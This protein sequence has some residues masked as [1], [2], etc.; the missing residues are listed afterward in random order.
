[1]DNLQNLDWDK[2]LS[3]LQSFATT[4]MARD[5]LAQTSPFS[6]PKS[7]QEQLDEIKEALQLV[8]INLRPNLEGL[9]SFQVWYDRLTKKATLKVS[10]LLDVKKF[11]FDVVSVH[12]ALMQIDGAWV[13]KSLKSLMESRKILSAI[14]QLISADGEIR[15]DASETLFNLFNE[16]KQLEKNIR[17]TLDRIVK[18][19][20]MESLLQDKYVTNREGRWVL[21]IKSGKQHDIEGIIHDSSQTKQTVFMEPQDIIPVN[22]RL[23]DVEIQIEKEVQKLLTQLSNF[24][25][26]QCSEFSQSQ[27][28]LL[29]FDLRMAQA[30]FTSKIKGHFFEFNDKHFKLNDVRHPLL[31][32]QSNMNVV[33][34]TVKFEENKKILIL[35]GPN[36][37]GKTILLKA[38]GLCAHM[39]RCGLPLPCGFGSTLPFFTKIYVAIGDT[40][41]VDQHLSTFA[42][43]LK[44]LTEAT[45]ARGSNQLILV[46]EICGST[47]PEEGAALSKAFIDHYASNK[48]YGIVTSHLGPLKQIWPDSSSI[49]CGSMEYDKNPTYKLFM[50]I[51][52]RSYAI[53]TA[54]SVG[55]PLSILDKA[56]EYLSPESRNKEI[57]MDEIESYKNQLLELTKKLTLENEIVEQQREKYKKLIVKFEAE[58]QIWIQKSIERAEKKIEKLIEEM[59]SEKSISLNKLK[60]ELPQII[61][62]TPS[63]DIIASEKDFIE[64]VVPGTS[65][66]IQSL[67]QDGI[68][69]GIPN[70]KGEVPV[71]SKSMRVQ[72]HWK[73]LTPKKVLSSVQTY[74]HKTSDAIPLQKEELQIDLRGLTSDDA[75][76][77]LERALDKAV[78]NQAD[79]IKI[80]HGHGSN[81]LKKSVRS[82]LSRSLYIQKWQAGSET[83]GDGITWAE[84]A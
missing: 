3:K 82:Y 23:R 25:S 16:K 83:E 7:A 33:P 42:A 11:C 62:Y 45:E 69:Q 15:S 12:K 74:A 39:A 52:G 22:N 48:V 78:R 32:L 75:I 4:Q 36:A 18:S 72:I 54:K 30:Q 26:S 1:M 40:Q 84:L 2:T 49:I 66:F 10:E 64:K 56:L 34:N 58:K 19:Y 76:I 47:D 21:P 55:V 20:Q 73:D 80:I 50:G 29:M 5:F 17:Q 9:D 31:V 65:V 59:K 77:K 14:D 8:E 41:N 81:A 53:K 13:K 27:I 24:L 6:N 38:I 44:T 68:V 61:K 35:T 67:N 28:T 46:D 43:H 71:L 57:Q 63:E 37:G 60:L 70:S 51:H 79:K